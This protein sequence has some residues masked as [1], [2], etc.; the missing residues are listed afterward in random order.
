MCSYTTGPTGKRLSQPTLN[1][2]EELLKDPSWSPIRI[3]T[4]LGIGVTTIKRIR[5]NFELF[6]QPY[7][8]SFEK[9]GRPRAL[10]YEQEQVGV[11]NRL[12]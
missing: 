6:G 1:Q 7:P 10:N 11:N 4:R 2:I 8:T 12:V 9:R 3:S 5:L